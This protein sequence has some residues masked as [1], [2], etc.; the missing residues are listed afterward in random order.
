MNR[1]FTLIFSLLS[2]L[3]YGSD[4][5]LDKLIEV[6]KCWRE[7]PD[8]HAE[9]LPAYATQNER[10]W[11]RTH[12]SLVEGVLR[13]RP[14][15]HLSAAQRANRARC[16][17]YLHQYWLSGSFPI[18]DRYSYRTP[19]FIDRHNNFCAVG[20]LVKAS[21]H[22]EVSRMIASRAN[23]AYVREM[24]YPELDSW[25]ADNGFTRDELAWIQPGYD[26]EFYCFNQPIGGGVNGAVNELFADDATGRL[27]VGGKFP[28]ANGTLAVNNI[29]YVTAATD[30]TYTWHAMGAGVNGTVNAITKYD[31]KIFVGG[32]FDTVGE[33]PVSNVAYWDGSSWHSAGCL[34]GVVRDLAVWQGVLFA[35]GDFDSCATGGEV[36]FARWTGLSWLPLPGLKGRVN[37]L[38]PTT[39]VLVLGGAFSYGADT[40]NV[41]SWTDAGSFSL[42]AN[43]MNNEVMDFETY[44]DS[45]YAV[46]HR[47]DLVDTNSLFMVLRAGTWASGEKFYFELDHFS[48]P[49]N[50]VSFTTLC[51]EPSGLNLGGLFQYETPIVPPYFLSPYSRNCFSFG[52]YAQTVDSAVSKM[53]MF[54][55]ELFIGGTF[56]T[57]YGPGG[58]VT[59]NG[60]ARRKIVPASVPVSPLVRVG[61]TPAPNPVKSG[62]TITITS[63]FNASHYALHD[64]AGRQVAAG[65]PDSSSKIIV[66]HTAPGL[67]MVFLENMAGEKAVMKV[68]VE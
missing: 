46:C 10:E 13:Q 34:N 6:N 14:T 30:S 23:L 24:H 28:M 33:M 59:L 3:A 20:Y 31:G 41:I 1:L 29:A 63:G 35:A 51:A 2:G 49:Y 7:Q 60:I 57:G 64:A 8:V 18:N 32:T 27:Y 55:N 4:P 42:F 11:I 12:L 44:K 16:L 62:G 48:A 68:M 66:P 52:N 15:C 9:A 43:G 39:A 19:I 26:P 47:T 53:V 56:K 37:T 17:G 36:N 38:E 65:R 5:T 58:S 61:A 45:L 54:D 25:A 21:G 40:V 67:Y 22:E 50:D